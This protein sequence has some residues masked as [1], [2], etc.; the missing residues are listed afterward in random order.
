[1][2]VINYN[3]DDWQ[4]LSFILTFHWFCKMQIGYH[5]A[6]LQ[7]C[8]IYKMDGGRRIHS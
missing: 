6:N 3:D 8:I 2:I 5:I 4:I 7:L 1:M